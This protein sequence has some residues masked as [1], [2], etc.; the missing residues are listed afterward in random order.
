MVSSTGFSLGS[1]VVGVLAV[2]GVATVSYVVIQK[3]SSLFQQS[4][5][6]QATSDTKTEVSEPASLT[7][8]TRLEDAPKI[9][10][11]GIVSQGGAGGPAA[12]HSLTFQAPEVD[13]ASRFSTPFPPPVLR[14][15]DPATDRE[16][17]I[18]G[19]FTLC[20]GLSNP[21][22]NYCFI[23]SVF[24]GWLVCQ[25]GSL[26]RKK[27]TLERMQRTAEVG[28]S[29]GI[30][31]KLLEWIRGY[32]SQDRGS[33]DIKLFLRDVFPQCALGRLR[34]LAQEVRGN[35]DVALTHEDADELIRWLLRFT[36]DETPIYI[37]SEKCLDP[38]GRNLIPEE[39]RRPV[40]FDRHVALGRE[41][42]SQRF[43]LK[44]MILK[45]FEERVDGQKLTSERLVITSDGGV[46]AERIPILA[47]RHLLTSAPEEIVLSVPRFDERWQR[48]AGSV[49][50][51]SE[52]LEM[53]K[54]YFVDGQGVKYR[55]RSVIC[56]H[57]TAEFGHYTTY[58]RKINTE[59]SQE[60]YCHVDDDSI[61]W[62]YADTQK[63]ALQ[64][65]AQNAY[66]IIY[67]KISE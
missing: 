6:E 42:G 63:Q 19:I 8:A 35:C 66:I 31:N 62:H 36:E 38:R 24:Q 34:I 55:L 10:G 7:T 59:T 20:R 21:G 1:T 60:A 56:H 43:V 2:A 61:T 53:P 33:F 4:I 26:L 52:I 25:K 29:L 40:I 18:K 37:Q 47:N 67:D 15:Y 9:S 28:A 14:E 16:L 48:L 39:R 45:H 44:D 17:R 22:K 49:E 51:L 65:A 30:V 13:S 50:G 58:V 46:K 41:H 64:T 57:G 54:E 27:Q 32:E 5:T 12:A 23:N 3:I 11:P